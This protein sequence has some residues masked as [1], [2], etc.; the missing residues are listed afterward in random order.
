MTVE[1]L[2]ER[3]RLQFSCGGRF[4]L[5]TQKSSVYKGEM[6][7]GSKYR[8]NWLGRF[9]GSPIPKDVW[10]TEYLRKLDIPWSRLPR[11]LFT[12]C[13]FQ[14]IRY[15]LSLFYVG[16]LYAGLCIWVYEII[17]MWTL[18]FSSLFKVL[19]VINLVVSVCVCRLLQPATKYSQVG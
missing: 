5:K 14:C 11:R 6:K 18:Q 8:R 15:I 9:L 13:L 3:W 1:A 7:N 16:L 17:T 12:F 4:V 2:T 10:Q 19:T